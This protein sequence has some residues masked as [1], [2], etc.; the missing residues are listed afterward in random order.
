M[1]N[2][3]GNTHN[4]NAADGNKASGTIINTMRSVH[5]NS[6]LGTKLRRDIKKTEIVLIPNKLQIKLTKD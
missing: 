1:S 5:R 2:G 3:R 4:K 6:Q